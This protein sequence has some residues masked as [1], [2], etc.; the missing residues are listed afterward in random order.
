VTEK[1]FRQTIQQISI[2]IK[3][4]FDGPETY[5]LTSCLFL[6]NCD[7]ED[8]Q[9]LL[10]HSDGSDAVGSEIPSGEV[11]D[12]ELRLVLRPDYHGYLNRWMILVFEGVQQ[13]TQL[14]STISK[15]VMSTRIAGCVRNESQDKVTKSLSTDA[16]PFIPQVAASYF[17]SEVRPFSCSFPRLTLLS[18]IAPVFL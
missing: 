10:T 5:R 2:D 7:S 18:A 1:P 15:C 9:Y 6:P 4:N 12:L 8:F 3:E 13:H 17:D 14:S 11:T 16:A